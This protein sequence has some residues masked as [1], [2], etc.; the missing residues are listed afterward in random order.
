MLKKV[1]PV[2]YLTLMIYD[3]MHLKERMYSINYPR[4]TFDSCLK[5]DLFRNLVRNTKKYG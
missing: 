4:T 3:S 2:D 1:I 5:S